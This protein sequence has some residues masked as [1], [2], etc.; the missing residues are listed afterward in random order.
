[1]ARQRKWERLLDQLRE[2]FECLEDALDDAADLA[3]EQEREITRLQEEVDRLT[4]QI[5]GAGDDPEP[6]NRGS[7]RPGSAGWPLRFLD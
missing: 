6:T 5:D 1:M 7:A 3:T 2:E 4:D